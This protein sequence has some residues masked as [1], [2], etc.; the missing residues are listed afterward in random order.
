MTVRLAL[1]LAT[2]RVMSSS[3][4]NGRT[5]PTT[6]AVCSGATPT[7]DSTAASMNSEADGMGAV[8][9]A[10]SDP[11]SSMIASIVPSA[12]TPSA[13]RL[14]TLS[15]PTY[16][17]VPS[18][19]ML[20]PIGSTVEATAGSIPRSSCATRRATGRVAAEDAVEKA[21][22]NGSTAA[23]KKRRIDNR[24]ASRISGKCTSRICAATPST[25]HSASQ[26][27]LVNTATPLSATACA[28]SASTP[29]GVTS[30]TIRTR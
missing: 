6:S 20:A 24:A 9:K 27:I 25:T 19:P 11:V 26:P 13:C 4:S 30:I 17:A 1:A 23:R 12:R 29:K 2:V 18:L 28:I 5:K 8:P 14:K 10:A 22:S 7:A 16:I 15:S 21:T 3:R